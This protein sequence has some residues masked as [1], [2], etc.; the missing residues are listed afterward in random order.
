MDPKSR[1]QFCLTSFNELQQA[2]AQADALPA[3]AARLVVKRFCVLDEWGPSHQRM[4]QVWAAALPVPLYHPSVC[5]AFHVVGRLLYQ[6]RA[7]GDRAGP[8]L[9]RWAAGC[10]AAGAEGL[11]RV[12]S[13][14]FVWLNFLSDAQLDVLAQVPR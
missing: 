3:A 1:L 6:R 12:D 11:V 4:Y 10:L 2:D 14:T 5:R 8:V 13:R 7:G 9:Q